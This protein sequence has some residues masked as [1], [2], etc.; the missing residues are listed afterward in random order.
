[1]TCENVTVKVRAKSSHSE[2]VFEGHQAHPAANN[3][4]RGAE[5]R[6][7]DFRAELGAAR[8]SENGGDSAIAVVCIL[9]CII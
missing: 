5:A 3:R 4:P 1:M 2:G 7:S 8:G 9:V 6:S